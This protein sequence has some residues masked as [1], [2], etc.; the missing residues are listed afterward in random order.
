M[1]RVTVS[2]LEN[3]LSEYLRLVKG[4]EV[5]EV[6]EH[7]IPI[8]RIEGVRVPAHAPSQAL[9]RLLRGGLARGPVKPMEP[10]FWSFPAFPCSSDAARTVIDGRGDR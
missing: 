3:R 4:G 1:Q 6:L 7:S 10:G 9:E 5:L 8:A 2:E